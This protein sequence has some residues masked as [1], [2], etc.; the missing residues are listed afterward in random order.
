MRSAPRS[1]RVEAAGRWAGSN[2]KIQLC[3][4]R[5][6]VSCRRGGSGPDR[7][8]AFPHRS[9]ATASSPVSTACSAPAARAASA[10]SSSV[11]SPASASRTCSPGSPNG[12]PPGVGAPGRA[13]PPRWRAPGRTRRCSK[14]SRTC[15][16]DIPP[17]S[18]ACVTSSGRR[19]TAPC[20]GGSSTGPV[21]A[22][23]SGCSWPP[24]SCSGSPRRASASC[25]S[26]TT[27]TR[28]TRRAC[29][30]C[31]TW[32]AAAWASGCCSSSRTGPS[33]CLPPL[34]KVRDSLVGR[35]AALTLDL[36]AFDRAACATLLGRVARD[37]QP[38]FVEEVWQAS[39]GIPFRVLELARHAGGPP[40]PG[41]ARRCSAGSPSARSTCCARGGGRCDFRHRRVPR[42]VRAGGAGRVRRGWTPRCGA[43]VL[44]RTQN[45]YR[46][47]PPPRPRRPARRPAGAPRASAAPGRRA[48]AGRLGR[49]PRPGRPPPPAGR[50]RGRRRALRPAGRRDRGGGRG[51]PGRARPRGLGAWPR[52]GLPSGRRLLALRAD[53]LMA[54]GDGGAQA[55]Y[56]A[57]LAADPGR[58]APDTTRLL[59]ARLSRA[60]VLAGDLD[61]A[62][63]AIEAS[64]RTAGRPTRRS[65]SRRGTWPTRGATWT[66]PRSP[67]RRRRGA[68]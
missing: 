55:A 45:G 62:A 53:L 40:R 64:S 9:A 16:G 57:A 8:G 63:A 14:R 27:C 34:A 58:R 50:R 23:T 44:E 25:S 11:A 49:L 17:C 30:C 43:R 35:S 7:P 2:R 39:G 24:P 1:D 60:A 37:A 15:A 19:S 41:R 47:P 6:G 54:V 4:R 67:R 68:C 21:T 46:L 20:P 26:S 42:L 5:P 51:V 31:T 59:R 33:P 3:G 36:T 29:G 12:P 28:R 38:D 18:T 32:R 66:R 13:W 65:C 48:A 10:R 52:A 56:S 61:T 22:G